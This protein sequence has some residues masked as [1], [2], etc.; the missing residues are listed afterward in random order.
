MSENSF[1][2]TSFPVAEGADR[3]TGS[4]V[5][6]GMNLAGNQRVR[7]T[8][9]HYSEHIQASPAAGPPHEQQAF[10]EGHKWSEAPGK[11]QRT[12]GNGATE[13]SAHVGYEYE[14]H[15]F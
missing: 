2:E 13:P 6:N 11:V 8:L 9:V 5:D 3:T 12:S 1:P 7:A 10:T 15:Q 14:N 4:K